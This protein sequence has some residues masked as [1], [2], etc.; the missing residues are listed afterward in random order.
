MART[1]RSQL[2]GGWYHCI[3]RGANRATIFFDD[4]DY[5]TFESNLR[6]VANRNGLEVGAYCL[7]P[8]HWHIVLH[9]HAACEMT[10]TFK[11]LLNWHSRA[12]HTKYRTTG[13]GPIYQ[14]RFKSF[15]IKDERA[16]N[17][18]CEYVELNPVR[19]GLVAEA[20]AWRWSSRARSAEGTLR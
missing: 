7:M 15:P 16:L 13:L 4:Q 1:P 12:H 6:D 5:S 14:G 2:P 9:C 10:A 8:N 17:T 19:A 20:N 18:I 3:N 11:E